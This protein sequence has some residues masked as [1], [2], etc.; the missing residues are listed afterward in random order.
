MEKL[1]NRRLKTKK[2]GINQ[3]EVQFAL[4][5]SPF[6]S[7]LLFLDCSL[8]TGALMKSC[9]DFLFFIK[10]VNNFSKR[11]ITIGIVWASVMSEWL[12]ERRRSNGT[13]LRPSSRSCDHPTYCNCTSVLLLGRKES[14]MSMT[15]TPFPTYFAP[16][17][18]WL[19]LQPLSLKDEPLL[20]FY[21]IDHC[22]YILLK[23][24]T[25]I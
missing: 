25:A 12:E 5:T 11:W 6:L 24:I 7:P 20:C 9:R 4:S 14:L 23:F 18:S 15:T 22:P 19:D 13:A 3:S 16:V 17:G 21:I 1:A 10:N 8:S 2:P